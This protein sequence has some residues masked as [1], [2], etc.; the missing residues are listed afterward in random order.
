MNFSTDVAFLC[1]LRR[2][3]LGATVTVAP[4][5]V[6]DATHDRHPC[7]VNQ[8]DK[9]TA[10]LAEIKSGVITHKN[11]YFYFIFYPAYL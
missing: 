3:L 5:C 1:F 4:F 11:L 7:V 8:L 6:L 9:I 2:K 10:M